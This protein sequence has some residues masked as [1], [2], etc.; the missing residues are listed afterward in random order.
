MLVIP[1]IICL[2]FVGSAFCGIGENFERAGLAIEAAARLSWMDFAAERYEASAA[3]RLGFLLLPRL[4]PYVGIGYYLFANGP[5]TSHGLAADLGLNYYFVPQ[6]EE[7]SGPVHGPGLGFSN[8][9]WFGDAS[10]YGVYAA[11]QYSFLY[12]FT[13]RIA[14]SARLAPTLRLIPGDHFGL[15]LTGFLGISYFIRAR[16]KVLI[17][18]D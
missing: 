1:A 10:P 12:F 16:E 7:S 11:V 2:L 13:E 3:T 15:V 5:S 14:L 18:V 4:E 9:V 6:P 8:V 17:P